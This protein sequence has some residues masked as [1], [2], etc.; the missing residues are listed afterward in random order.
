MAC[1]FLFVDALTGFMLLKFGINT[2]LSI[3][4]KIIFLIIGLVLL[5]RNSASQFWLAISLIY[6]TILWA[7]TKNLTNG[8]SHL[9]EDLGDGLK[10]FSPIIVFFA[11]SHFKYH[12]AY[13]FLLRFLTINLAVLFVNLGATFIGVARSTY[14]NYGA[15]G[16][17]Q[18]GNSL[19]AIIVLL[20]SF[21][22]AV[23]IRRSMLSYLISFLLLLVVAIA[24]GTKGGIIGLVL[25][26]ILVFVLSFRF[27]FTQVVISSLSLIALSILMFV[28][29]KFLM[30]S[31]LWDRILFFYSNG[32]LARVILSSRDSFLMNILPS[33]IDSGVSDLLLGL[34]SEKL[35]YFGKGK[36]EIDPVDI[37]F[38]FGFL[39]TTLYFSLLFLVLGKVF[40]LPLLPRDSIHKAMKLSATSSALVL[41]LMAF[42]AGHVLIN[43]VVTFTWGCLLALPFWYRNNMR[44]RAR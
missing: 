37:V 26:A 40:M 25:T 34:G 43:G 12:K 11:F 8:L 32:G 35:S 28:G 44:D 4:Y 38:K 7:L 3:I 24:I 42:I 23:S 27:T 15:K 14:G 33:F 21:L 17:F 2:N 13:D 20:S 6:L 22:L 39:I 10:L 1:N 41:V 18:S 9:I 31:L 16:F 36:V 5:S 30:Q 29:F 19:S